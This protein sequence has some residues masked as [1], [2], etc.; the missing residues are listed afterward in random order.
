MHDSHADS[1][2]RIQMLMLHR[3]NQNWS[4]F[5]Y[6]TL[7][8]ALCDSCCP[9]P[10]EIKI[11]GQ[12]KSNNPSSVILGFAKEN[13]KVSFVGCLKRK[14][15]CQDRTFELEVDETVASAL[16]LLPNFLKIPIEDDSPKNIMYKQNIDHCVQLLEDIDANNIHRS[17]KHGHYIIHKIS[18]MKKIIER[19][20]NEIGTDEGLG[21]VQ[22]GT[23]SEEE[24][25]EL[26][27]K[28]ITLMG[29]STMY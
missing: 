11:A 9:D 27:H 6:L 22:S 7:G 26:T 19:L 4:F 8:F 25:I 24:H 29:G 2:Q 20:Q 1:L 3:E 14:K 28:S 23:D 16:D 12:H 10:K 21:F 17:E 18:K 5:E 15:H 13:E